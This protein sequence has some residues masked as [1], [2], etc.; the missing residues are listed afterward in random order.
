MAEVLSVLANANRL[1]LLA[2]LRQP[3]TPSEIRLTPE[4]VHEGENPA[5]TISRQAVHHHLEKLLDINAV[6]SRS[7]RKGGVVGDEYVVNHQQIFAI[8]EEFRKLGSL[9][10]LDEGAWSLR[11]QSLQDV[12]RAPAPEGPSLV[13][14]HGLGEGNVF[15][16]LSDGLHMT[17]TWVV[18][19]RLDADVCLDYDPYVSSENT[20]IR[21]VPGSGF[22]VEDLPGSR[23]GTFVNWAR[24]PAGSTAP[25]RH[26]DILGLGKTLLVFRSG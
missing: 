9:R 16:L 6:L 5:R 8:S 21:F 7:V 1:R 4:T 26:G 11:T 10:P 15:P 12:R 22:N 20:R 2:Q 17:R 25:L 14:V 3:R 19:R 13:L 24:V 18:G 23:N